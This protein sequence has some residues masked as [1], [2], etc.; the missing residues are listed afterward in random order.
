MSEQELKMW[1]S[2]LKFYMVMNGVEPP[3]DYGKL[4][5]GKCS[6]TCTPCMRTPIVNKL[7]FNGEHVFISTTSLIEWE[8]KLSLWKIIE[9]QNGHCVEWIKYV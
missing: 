9:S 7:R 1:E 8:K 5:K 2:K 4:C 6:Y 3:F